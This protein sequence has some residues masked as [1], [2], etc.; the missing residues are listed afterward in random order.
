M[1][2]AMKNVLTSHNHSISFNIVFN[3]GKKLQNEGIHILKLLPEIIL[4]AEEI[5]NGTCSPHG[6]TKDPYKILIENPKREY[7]MEVLLVG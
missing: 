4:L 6:T 1:S 7:C 3:I 5:R 2:Q